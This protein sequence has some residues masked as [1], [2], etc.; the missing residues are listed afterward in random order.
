MNNS[1]SN[2][3]VID[4]LATEPNK[5]IEYLFKAEYSFLCATVYRMIKDSLIAEDIVQEVFMELWKKRDTLQIRSIRAYLKRAAVNKTLNYIRDNKVKFGDDS[6]L[7]F[8]PSNDQGF[9]DIELAQLNDRI[10]QILDQLPPKCRVVF[11]LNRFEQLTYI[12]IAEQLNISTKTVENHI[13][14]ALKA[15]RQGLYGNTVPIFIHLILNFYLLYGG[16]PL[17]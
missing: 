17:V 5:A 1:Y 9:H 14:K 16:Y 2:Q 7:Q 12:E 13:S 8:T 11:I 6:E 3:E 10:N 15:L 4:L